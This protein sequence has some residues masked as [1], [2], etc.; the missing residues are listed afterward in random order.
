VFRTVHLPVRTLVIIAALLVVAVAVVIV[1]AM[2]NRPRLIPP[3]TVLASGQ[4]WES[5]DSGRASLLG[6]VMAPGQAEETTTPTGACDVAGVVDL[7]TATAQQLDGLPGVGP[8]LA[9]RIMEWRQVHGR[10]TH[11]RELRE[12]KG[13]GETTYQRLAPLVRV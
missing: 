1:N 13:I 12:I 11:V 5:V 2:V 3:P 4:P 6:Q 7:N 8:V 9:G 10:F